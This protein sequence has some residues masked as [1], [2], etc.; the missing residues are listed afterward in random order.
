[1]INFGIAGPDGIPAAVRLSGDHAFRSESVRA[2]ELGYRF[3]MGRRASLD[4]ASFYNQYR[5][6][7]TFEPAGAPFFERQASPAYLVIPFRE[8]NLM[9]GETYGVDLAASVNL[10]QRWR[11]TPGYSWLRVDLRLDPSSGDTRS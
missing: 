5:Q 3:Q 4:L 2:H 10:T 1:Q 8:A 11:L 7:E 6:L 9:R